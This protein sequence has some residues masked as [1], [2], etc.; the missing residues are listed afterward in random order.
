MPQPADPP[1]REQRALVRRH[2]QRRPQPDRLARGRRSRRLVGR[3]PADRRPARR[4]AVA[5]GRRA[6]GRPRRRG[7][8]RRVAAPASLSARSVTPSQCPRPRHRTTMAPPMT[9]SPASPSIAA[10]RL[11]LGDGQAAYDEAVEPGARRALGA[12]PLRP[13][14]DPLV[15]E[16]ARPGRDRRA[17][18]LARRPG[19]LRDADRRAR[20]VRRGD[21][22]RRVHHRRRRRDGRQQ[23]RAGR[24][25][26]TFG[27]A[28]G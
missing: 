8:V 23:P 2:V 21:P 3:G 14:H 7:R 27:I 9:D 6:R 4:P 13:R 19:P 25:P 22:R 20:G 18:R 1:R 10:T 16:R 26:R 17:A 11:T 28:D 5:R 15:D 24:L 12:A